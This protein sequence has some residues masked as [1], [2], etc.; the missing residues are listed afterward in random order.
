ML[1][2]IYAALPSDAESIN[3]DPVSN[4]W[5]R[6][7]FNGLDNAALAALLFALG[8]NDNGKA[9]EGEDCLVFS[10]DKS[11]PWIFHLPESLRNIMSDLNENEVTPLAERWVKQEELA[12]NKLSASDVLP[13][14]E[15]LRDFSIKA[16]KDNQQLMLWMCL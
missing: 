11:G 16:L 12:F 8:E 6:L 14:I 5:P 9:L 13:I 7:E 4:Q 10:D 3:K 1:T 15:T 2:N